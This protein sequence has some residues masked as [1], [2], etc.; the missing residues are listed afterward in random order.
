MEVVDLIRESLEETA[1]YLNQKIFEI[2]KK[3]ILSNELVDNYR[4]PSSRQLAKEL[5]VARNT[6]IL[7]YEQLDIEGYIYTLP[8]SGTYIKRSMQHQSEGRLF[9]EARPSLRGAAIL[10]N[11]YTGAITKSIPFT[12]FAPDVSL[13]PHRKFNNL[14]HKIR[15]NSEVDDLH[16][17][18]DG[19]VYELKTAIA[20][21]LSESRNINC[22]ADQI[23]VDQTQDKY[24]ERFRISPGTSWT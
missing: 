14:I 12:P 24:T 23:L 6:I 13:F 18:S 7:V 16:Y 17:T 11:T 15:R 8:G 20:N 9:F 2:L 5:G 4:L 19:G 10:E 22:E 21:H 3:L 1:G